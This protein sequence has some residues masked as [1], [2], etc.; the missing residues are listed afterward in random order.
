LGCFEGFE[1]LAAEAD[2]PA[3]SARMVAVPSSISDGT[4]TA[5]SSPPSARTRGGRSVLG[6]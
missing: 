2:D 6:R 3:T 4:P 5:L 1:G